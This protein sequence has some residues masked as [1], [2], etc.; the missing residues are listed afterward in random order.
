METCFV[1]GGDIAAT[2]R[3]RAGW[4][5]APGRAIDAAD[6]RTVG[7]HAGA[8]AFTVGQRRGVG[9]AVGEPR[10]VSRVDPIAN[11]IV[12]ARRADLE[13]RELGIE[14]ATFIAGDPPGEA[15][16]ALAQVRHRATP[17][18]ASVRRLA[19]ARHGRRA[20]RI[21]TEE[22][23]WAAAPGQAC[24][25]YDPHEPDVV[26]GGGRIARPDGGTA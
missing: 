24:V 8:A 15:F 5:P 17:V 16:R 10:Y 3:T 9:V 23:V 18:P 7:E 12:L 1:P 2:L 20:W 14:D 13:V 4:S 6:G 26:I 11:T 21:E 25:L 19:G 22:P